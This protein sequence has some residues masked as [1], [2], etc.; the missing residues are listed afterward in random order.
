M[1]DAPLPLDLPRMDGHVGADPVKIVAL[2][3]KL[4]FRSLARQAARH[5][6]RRFAES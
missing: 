3:E 4:E 6:A 2:L 1:V 5:F